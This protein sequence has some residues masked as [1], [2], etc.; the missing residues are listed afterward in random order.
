M[1][2]TAEADFFGSAGDRVVNLTHPHELKDLHPVPQ[3]VEHEDEVIMVLE[4]LALHLRN[5]FDFIL[6]IV[7]FV[8]Q[9]ADFIFHEAGQLDVE[10]RIC[11]GDGFEHPAQVIL[12]EFC[13]F[14]EPVVGE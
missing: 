9:L 4:R 3:V 13:E 5:R 10:I 7:R 2:Y 11:V 12:V 1:E 14:R 6:W 8:H